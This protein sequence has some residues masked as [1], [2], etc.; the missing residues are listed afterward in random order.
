MTLA[1]IPARGGSKGILRKNIRQLAGKPLIAWTIQAALAVKGIERVV[2]STEDEEIAAVAREWG[3]E[4]PFLRPAELATDTAPGIAPVLHAIDE[5]PEHE[6]L[7]LLQ[8]TSP[9]RSAA[10]IVELLAFARA[11]GARSV[12][13]VREVDDHPFWMLRRSPDGALDRYDRTAEATRRQD[14]SELYTLNGAMYWNTRDYLIRTKA[15]V[16]DDTLGFVMDAQS[17]IDIDTML[18]WRIA[19]L[20]LTAPEERTG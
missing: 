17:S 12:V 4:T 5:L 18:D 7:I 10:Q 9:L 1:L 19:E 14:L 20:L 11:R 3:A 15:L 6:D 16:T 2:V 13:S 8:A